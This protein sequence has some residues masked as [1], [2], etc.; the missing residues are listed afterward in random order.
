MQLS[1][2]LLNAELANQ[3]SDTTVLFLPPCIPCVH[4]FPQAVKNLVFLAK[5][6]HGLEIAERISDS[7]E[8]ATPK[9]HTLDSDEVKDLNWLVGRLSRLA[10]FEAG[11]HPKESMKV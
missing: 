3:V 10:R 7:K 5:V 6:L 11:Y 8:Q 1:S 9:Q 4:C 2:P